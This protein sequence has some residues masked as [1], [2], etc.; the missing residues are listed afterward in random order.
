[1]RRNFLLEFYKDIENEERDYDKYWWDFDKVVNIPKQKYVELEGII[2]KLNKRTLDLI[3][4]KKNA[5]KT[6]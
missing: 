6:T 1:M 3:A 4:R 5:K 2:D